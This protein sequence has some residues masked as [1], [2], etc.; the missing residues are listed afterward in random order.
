[1]YELDK[2]AYTQREEKKRLFN[3][4]FFRYND[5]IRLKEI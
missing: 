4:F 3:L 2:M 5:K 1:M